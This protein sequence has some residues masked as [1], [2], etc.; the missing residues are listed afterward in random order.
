MWLVFRKRTLAIRHIEQLFNLRSNILDVLK[1][2]LSPGAPILFAIAVF[3]WVLPVAT[4]YPPSALTVSFQRYTQTENLSVSILDPSQ[5]T[6]DPWN[7]EITGDTKSMLG[8]VGISSFATADS[9]GVINAT[10][11]VRYRY[12]SH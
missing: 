11:T 10:L 8:R 5:T 7:L 9:E 2:Q 4:V 12:D 1:V 6:F 3:V